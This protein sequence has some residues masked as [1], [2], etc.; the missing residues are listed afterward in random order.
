MLSSQKFIV[1]FFMGISLSHLRLV[2][3]DDEKSQVLFFT[4]GERI[5]PVPFFEKLKSPPGH[6]FELFHRLSV[7]PCVGM[8]L[9]S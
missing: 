7:Y 5:A 9:G 3:V 6:C 1:L 2:F 4:C 8:I